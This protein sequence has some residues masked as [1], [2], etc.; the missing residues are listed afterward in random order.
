MASAID[1][2]LNYTGD[3]MLG[4]LVPVHQRAGPNSA[5]CGPIQVQYSICLYRVDMCGFIATY[6]TIMTG[7]FQLEYGVQTLEAMLYTVDRINQETSLLPGIRLGLL[8]YDSCDNPT[9]ALEQSLDIVKG[10]F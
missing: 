4:A 5:G 10:R 1:V 6:G 2:F 7:L 3:L 8:V 9:H